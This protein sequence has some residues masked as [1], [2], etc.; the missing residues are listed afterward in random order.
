MP[1]DVNSVNTL[2]L[3]LSILF[4]YKYVFLLFYINAAH[5]FY[6]FI[7]TAEKNLL[8]GHIFLHPKFLLHF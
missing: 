8:P 4:T 5:T 2:F 3:Y 1:N 7:M 6:K